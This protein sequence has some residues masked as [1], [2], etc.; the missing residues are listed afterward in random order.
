MLRFNPASGALIGKFVLPIS[1]ATLLGITFGYDGNLYVADNSGYI[2]RFDGSTGS[3]TGTFSC[4]YPSGAP[5]YPYDLTFDGNGNLY[6]SDFNINCNGVCQGAVLKFNGTTLAVMSVFVPPFLVPVQE[7]PGY[8]FSSNPQGL[9]FVPNGNTTGNLYVDWNIPNLIIF[10]NGLEGYLGSYNSIFEFNGTSGAA[11]AFSIP[12]A[13][14]PDFA[15]APDTSIYAVGSPGF[16]R[17]SSTTAGLLGSFGVVPGPPPG[18][19]LYS[20]ITYTPPCDVAAACTVFDTVFA[21]VHITVTQTLRLTVVNS[22]VP[23][24]PGVPVQAQLGFQNSEGVSVGPSQVVNL[25]PG[26]SASLDLVGSTLISSGR[27]QLQPVVTAPAGTLPGSL[28]GSVEVFTTSDGLGSVFYP[29]IPVPPATNVTGPPSFVPQ[30]VIYGQHMQ[31]NAMAP[32]D[33][34]C[35]ALLS[36]TNISG[37]QVGPEQQVNLSPGTMTSLIFNTNPYTESGRREFVPQITPNNPTGG[38]GVA[39]ACLGSAEVYLQKS[40]ITST[41][42]ISS[43]PIGTAGPAPV[44]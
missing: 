18:F 30:G 42:Q 14:Q 41:Y 31:I 25:N 35:V 39:P 29:G 6:V 27:V 7:Y 11:T 13:G 4:T 43:P 23:V 32:P 17:Y 20:K 16:N 8:F 2:R 24:G 38:L 12:Y 21:T 22:P 3:P 34:P 26:Q 15:F 33:S 19:I 36:F 37:N 10:S 40:G 5:C 44:N 9:H 28:Q 1:G